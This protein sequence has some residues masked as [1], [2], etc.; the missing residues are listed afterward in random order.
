MGKIY[1]IV[2]DG[3]ADHKLPQMNGRTPLQAADTPCLDG[4]AA[5]GQQSLV[6]ILPK[7][8]VPETDSGIMSLLGY[9]PTT[10]YCGRGALECMGLGLYQKFRFFAGF[11]INFASLNENTGQLDR[12]TAR[13]LSDAEL[14][15]FAEEINR[16]VSLPEYP[17]IQ[18]QLTAFGSHRG[19]LGFYSNTVEL[20]GNVSNTDPGFRRVGYFS[21][22]VKNYPP[23]PQLCVPLEQSDAAKTT[24][25]LVNRFTD[26]CRQILIASPVNQKRA[27]HGKMISNCII[28]RDGGSNAVPMQS[29][30]DKYHHRLAVY[31][32]LPCEATIASL[33]KADFSYT[34]KFALELEKEY[35]LQTVHD[36]VRSSADV[37]FCHLKGPDEPGHDQD[38]FGKK[39]AIEKIDQYF[40]CKLISR[41][42]P[43]DCV[44]VSC[45]HATPCDLGIHSDDKVPLLISGGGIQADN[46]QHFDEVS[47]AY[48][49][50]PIN[51]AVEILDYVCGGKVSE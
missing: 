15:C 32:Q 30:E 45:D 37:I 14:S 21:I 50:C 1:Y 10:Y 20:S 31:G 28:V 13:D 6:E 17:E 48:G 26:Q 42:R 23:K 19:I 9:E 35:L 5:A 38:P 7:G 4:L 41:L 25:E 27:W 22:P 44:V 39:K 2:L 49:D 29:F 12:R 47:A 16:N 8:I 24:A 40:F 51:Q 46:T 18:F 43:D 3:A 34:K 11:R 33:L 36:L